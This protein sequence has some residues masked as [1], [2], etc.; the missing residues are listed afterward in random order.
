M[1]TNIE[2]EKLMCDSVTNIC[3]SYVVIVYTSVL[4][5]KKYF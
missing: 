1:Y 3:F 5:S 2:T 4:H